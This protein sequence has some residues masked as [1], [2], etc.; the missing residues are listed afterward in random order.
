MEGTVRW[1]A[2][3]YEELLRLR[4]AV[5]EGRKSGGK[6]SYAQLLRAI[7][8]AVDNLTED[9]FC[10]DLIP[11]RYLTKRV[12]ARY[13]TDKLFRIPLVGYWRLLYTVVGDRTVIVAL[14]LEYMDHERYDRLFG[15]RKR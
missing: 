12:I 1:R 15:Y 3:A 5:A 8:K 4:E 6:P 9:P 7:E 14:I 10:G 13:G 2:E 11:R